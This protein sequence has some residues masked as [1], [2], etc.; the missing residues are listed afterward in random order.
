MRRVLLDVC[1]PRR[2]RLD[3]T[4]EFQ[5]DAAGDVGLDGLDDGALLDTIEGRYD[6]LV[7]RDRNLE[8]QQTIGGRPLAVVVLVTKD[9][10]RD[11]FLALVPDVALAI[12]VIRQGQVV[13]VAKGAGV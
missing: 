13:M 9:Q 6:V 1:V 12:R 8:Y 7:T 5:V 4:T 3:L 11:A 2:L 10:S